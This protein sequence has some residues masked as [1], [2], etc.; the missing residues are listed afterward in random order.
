MLIAVREEDRTTSR[1]DIPE[2]DAAPLRVTDAGPGPLLEQFRGSPLVATGKLTLVAIDAIAE[3]M[4]SRWP[5]RRDLVYEHFE[6]VFRKSVGE[7]A[8]VQRISET[9]Y[10]VAQSELSRAAGQ[11]RCLNCLREV[12]LHFLGAAPESDIRIHEI[13]RIETDGIYGQRIDATEVEASQRAER[14]DAPLEGEAPTSLDRWSP[15]TTARGLGVS[16]TCALEPVLSLR[17]ADRIGY[18]IAPRVQTLPALGALTRRQREILSAT[19]LERIDFATIARALDRIRNTAAERRPPTLIVPISCATLQ[20]RRGRGTSIDLLRNG[21]SFVQHGLICEL[22][23][24]EGAPIGALREIVSAIAPFCLHVVARMSD[25]EFG[26][27]AH[28]VGVGFGGVSVRCATRDSNAQFGE[29]VGRVLRG[30]S[31]ISKTVL[32]YQV[33]DLGKVATARERG[34]THATLAPQRL[35]IHFIDDEPW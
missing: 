31:C 34:A 5:I 7:Q 20:S 35:K 12:L 21:R 27:L 29:W 13:T 17:S 6:R 4:K 2:P 18:R 19:D 1:N 16:V 11:F 3:R 15:F 22:L 9:E 28:L 23:G 32:L 8:L 25:A 14:C 10:I 33:A 26:S 24:V 30:A